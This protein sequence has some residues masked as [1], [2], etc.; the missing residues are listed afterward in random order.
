MHVAA[1]LR[2]TDAREAATAAALLPLTCISIALP[3]PASGMPSPQGNGTASVLIYD[4][5]D[6]TF[7][8]QAGGCLT[9]DT[10]HLE[11]WLGPQGGG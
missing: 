1:R 8:W 9:G 10:C 2:L 4:W 11:F 7:T 6:G 5:K 3:L